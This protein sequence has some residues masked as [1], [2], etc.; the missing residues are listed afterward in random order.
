GAD[1]A[2][3]ETSFPLVASV[4]YVLV[5]LAVLAIAEL[6]PRLV[7]AAQQRRH[8]ARIAAERRARVARG[9]KVVRRHAPH[10]Y[11]ARVQTKSRARRR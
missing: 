10:G 2:L 8:E 5:A 4:L 1:P 3:A 11:A 7:A 9:S 6:T